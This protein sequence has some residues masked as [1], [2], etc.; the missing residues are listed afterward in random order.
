MLPH[1]VLQRI[2]SFVALVVGAVCVSCGGASTHRDATATPPPLPA[3]VS[4]AQQPQGNFKLGD[5]TLAALP[6][7]SADTGRLG[8][9]IY[10]IELPDQLNGRLVMYMHGCCPEGDTVPIESPP[11]RDA[12]IQEGF[13]WAASSFSANLY[14]PGT[15]ADE[16]AALWDLF[17]S[18][19]G[20]PS[21]TYVMG[22]SMGVPEQ[23][24]PPS[25]TRTDS[26][27][28]CLCVHRPGRFRTSATGS[29]T[30][31]S[32]AR[33]QPASHNSNSMPRTSAHS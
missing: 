3:P 11:D 1:L 33:M 20:R 30:S 15:A 7:A 5:P 17:V 26:T 10:Q 6:G 25:A 9:T 24:S 13:A 22:V 29:A 31:L 12:L 32:A 28:R 4:I 14:I 23:S 21:R 8:G 19:H 27:A 2:T 16:T 18:K